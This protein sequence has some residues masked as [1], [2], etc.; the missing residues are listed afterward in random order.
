M[1]KGKCCELLY[2]Q[3][4]Q[5]TEQGEPGRPGEA[6]PT[7][8]SKGQCSRCGLERQCTSG[9]AESDFSQDGRNAHFLICQYQKVDVLET[10]RVTL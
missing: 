1:E 2:Q 10:S 3:A 5:V 8:H 6:T 9:V 4:G 7:P